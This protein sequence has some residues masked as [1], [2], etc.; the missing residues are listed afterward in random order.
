[1]NRLVAH[2]ERVRVAIEIIAVTLLEN[3]EMLVENA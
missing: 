3:L 2:V 1:M